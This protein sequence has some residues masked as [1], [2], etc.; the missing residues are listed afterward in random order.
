MNSTAPAAAASGFCRDTL[1]FPSGSERCEAWL[2]RPA[3]VIGAAR[4]PV[5]VMAHGLGAVKELRLGAFAERFCKAGYICLVFDYRY[6]GGSTGAPRELLDIPR[7]LADWRAAVECARSLPGADADRVI[8]WGT[9]FGGGHAVVTAADDPRIAAAIAQCPFT[10]GLASAAAIPFATNAKLGAA[11]ARDLIAQALGRA[12]VRVKVAGKPGEVALMTS[13]DSMDGYH[14]LIEASGV[15]D[16]DLHNR[17]PARIALQI[18]LHRP[19]LRARDVR[20]P[21]LFCVCHNDSVAPAKPTLR[22]AA[23]APRGETKIYADGHF[24]I[25]LGEP[26]ERVI[27]DQLEFLQRHVPATAV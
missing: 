25:Y 8:A 23:R 15:A 22:H 20:C 3:T 19:G 2:Y 12:P 17:V 4:L 24:E 9:S 16:V 5:I 6:F 21:I 14:A 13:A 7:Q 27:A 18:P 11:A 1:F 10:D 26:F